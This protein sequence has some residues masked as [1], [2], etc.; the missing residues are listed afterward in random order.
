M[1]EKKGSK[2]V[3]DATNRP[4]LQR[5]PQTLAALP[6]QYVEHMINHA[7]AQGMGYGLLLTDMNARR[8]MGHVS[9]VY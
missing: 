1:K 6:H 7:T 5:P 8:L 2:F 9:H 3:D 4:T